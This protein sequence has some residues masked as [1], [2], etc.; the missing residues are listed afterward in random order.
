VAGGTTVVL[1]GTNLT[2][3]T[4]VTFGATAATLMALT[5]LPH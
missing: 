5:E 1:T 3:A 2:G 4:A